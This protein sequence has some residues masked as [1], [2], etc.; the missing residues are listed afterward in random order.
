[1]IPPRSYEAQTSFES[2]RDRMKFETFQ[3]SDSDPFSDEV[4]EQKI[5][6]KIESLG[7]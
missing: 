3:I 6:E 5:F 7:V 2:N 4:I 1:V